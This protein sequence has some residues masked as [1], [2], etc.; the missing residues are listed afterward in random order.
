MK[1]EVCSFYL[2]DHEQMR[3]TLTATSY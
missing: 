1:V 2:A 3:L